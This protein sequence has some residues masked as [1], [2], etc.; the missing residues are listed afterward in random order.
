MLCNNMDKPLVNKKY[1]LQKYPGKGGWVYTVIKEITPDK[2]AKFGWVQVSGTI[3]GFELKRYKL[4]PMKNGSM[5]FPVRAEIRKTIR[6]KEGDMVHITLYA[7]NS[8][9]EIPQEFLLCLED[10]PAA[11]QF[12]FKLSESEQQYY[13]KW[14]YTAKQE[15]TK[16]K[17]LAEA[18]IKLSKRRKF[19]DTIKE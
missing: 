17:R 15:D 9:I 7:D 1:K 10:E 19:Y 4:M 3:D 14:I 12:F 5:F 11:K 2:R 8:S 18:I 6:K 16:V 13:V